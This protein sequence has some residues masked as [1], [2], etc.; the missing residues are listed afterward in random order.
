MFVLGVLSIDP[1]C[2]PSV[3]EMG[4]MRSPSVFG[5]FSGVELGNVAD[6]G[7]EEGL[8]RRCQS[9]DLAHDPR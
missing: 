9:V 2:C 5:V 1:R 3:E 8:G 6:L 7:V 4:L